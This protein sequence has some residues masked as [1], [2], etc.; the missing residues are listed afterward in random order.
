MRIVE[1]FKN[2]WK[3][4]ELRTR[5]LWT[6]GLV[7]IYRLGC[8]IVLPGIDASLLDELH[9]QT[10]GGLMALLDMFSGG[11]FSNASIFAL[12]IMPYISASIIIQLLTMVLPSLRKLSMEGESGRNKIN[13]YTR[14]L[15]VVVLIFQSFAYLTNRKWVF[16]SEASTRK[17]IIRESVSFFLC[18]LGTG[19]LDWVLMYLLVDCLH[20]PDLWVKTGVNILVILLN[21][22]ASKLLVFKQKT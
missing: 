5:I 8:F 9:N 13:Q 4:E 21:Y 19:V 2:I 6:L 1:T 7:A 10:R 20:W 22:V 18:R 11:A 12:G 16:H 15:T 17:E 14:L 3:I